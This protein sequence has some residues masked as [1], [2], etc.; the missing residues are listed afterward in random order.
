ML[1]TRKFLIILVILAISVGVDTC[2]YTGDSYAKMETKARL[3][4]RAVIEP[5]TKISIHIIDTPEWRTNPSVSDCPLPSEP[6]G[7]Q[8]DELSFCT[9]M[10]GEYHFYKGLKV[11]V[12]SNGVAP[13]VRLN[14]SPMKS[15]Y[16]EIPAERIFVKTNDGQYQ[17]AEEDIILSNGAASRPNEKFILKF[18][19]NTLIS[20]MA[21]DYGGK[22]EFITVPTL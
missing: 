9:Q 11:T 2:N 16:D 19:V 8:K 18:K 15:V 3:S 14:V 20:D 4:V 22:M 17:S 21:G 6:P 10:P 13:T 1:K 7:T 12:K 5:Q